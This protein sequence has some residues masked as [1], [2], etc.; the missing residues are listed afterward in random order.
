MRSP[1]APDWIE[2]LDAD[3]PYDVGDGMSLSLKQSLVTFYH[4]RSF[5]SARVF[6]GV[7]NLRC[8]NSAPHR[9]IA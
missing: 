8:C 3:V 4:D 6:W 7:R 2:N 1:S 5:S 9:Y